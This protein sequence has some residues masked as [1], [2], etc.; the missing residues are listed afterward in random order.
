MVIVVHKKHTQK[1]IDNINVRHFI[2]CATRDRE[3][4]KFHVYL[5]PETNYK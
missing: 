3:T 1:K 5:F 2:S 4:D